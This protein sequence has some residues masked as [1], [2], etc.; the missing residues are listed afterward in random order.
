MAFKVAAHFTT[1]IEKWTSIMASK[2]FRSN[3]TANSRVRETMA[4]C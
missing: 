1:L 4:I 2:N 3:G